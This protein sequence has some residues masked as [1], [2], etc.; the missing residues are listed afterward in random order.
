MTERDRI[1]SINYA[2]WEGVQEGKAEGMQQKQNEI[3]RAFK[4]RGI[5][6]ETIAACTGLSVEEIEAL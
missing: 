2:R 3:A 6:V 5:D 4:A 1:N